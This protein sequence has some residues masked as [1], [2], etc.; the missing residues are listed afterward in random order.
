[1]AFVTWLRALSAVGTVA[2]AAGLFRDATGR[3]APDTV[4]AGT[5]E[6]LET[7]LANVVVAALKEAFDRD[8]AR[9]DLDRE[10][11]EAERARAEHAFRLEWVQRACEQTLMHIRLAAVLSF[12]AWVA[13]AGFVVWLAPVATST[14]VLLGLGWI[15]LFAAIGASFVAHRQLTAFLAGAPVAP[16]TVVDPP[17]IRAQT[18]LPWL[19]VAGCIL[20]AGSLVLAL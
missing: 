9:F 14:K 15:S 1:M 7:R 19:L 16:G 8:R 5:A 12:G 18:L 3:S 11:R 2:E 20:T 17:V 6:Q 10:L 13:S 4:A